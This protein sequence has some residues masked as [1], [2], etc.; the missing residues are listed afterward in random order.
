MT[1]TANTVTLQQMIAE[2]GKKVASA[3]NEVTS[4]EATLAAA[5]EKLTKETEERERLENLFVSSNGQILRVQVS[6]GP[7][8][9]IEGPK[10]AFE[11]KIKNGQISSHAQ[12]VRTEN[13]DAAGTSPNH[14]GGWCDVLYVINTPQ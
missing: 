2:Q 3:R 6:F 12:F 1:T 13:G 4:L 9:Q 14:W 10:E 8:F 7:D 5:K 11:L